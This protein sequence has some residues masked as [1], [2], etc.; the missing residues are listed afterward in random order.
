MPAHGLLLLAPVRAGHEEALR[1]TLNHFGN[2]IRG[3]RT[4]DAAT[5]PRLHFTRSHS[6]HF[7]R[8]T[9]LDD[10][11]RG[12]ARMR[13]LFASDYDGSREQHVREV[14]E[15][16]QSPEAIWGACEG[17]AGPERFDEFVRRHT[18]LPETH[19]IAFRGETLT[20]L[21]DAI[22]QKHEY[23]AWLADSRAD[24]VLRAWPDW[25]RIFEF[26]QGLARPL[27]R[28]FGGV[29]RALLAAVEVV[30]LM[31][32]RGCVR[33]LRAALQINSTLDRIWWIR[34]VNALFGNRPVPPPHFHS[35]ATPQSPPNPTPPG[36]PPEDAISQNQLTL[37]T[38]VLPQHRERLRA[39]L[40]LIDLFGR[41]LSPPGTLVGI[42]TI[43]TVRWTLLD[44]DQRLLMV[45]NYDG[46][47][48][49]YIDEFAEMILSGL[50]ALWT[51]APDYP[52]AGAQD[53][54]ALKQFL[55]RHQAPA[56]VFYSAYPETS[57]LNLKDDL[58]FARGTGRIFRQLITG[59][60]APT[61]ASAEATVRA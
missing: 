17:Y 30:A 11:K 38:D 46:S 60:P 54:A 41:H 56:N 24:Q 55:R 8:F 10:P 12:P 25:V 59:H 34:L 22:R 35:E 49:N 9:L 39:V 47:W 13:L 20:T 27:L 18:V 48:E 53:V 2:D 23:Q 52:R 50:D 31:R 28:F 37:L 26:L 57:V 4:A 36:Y 29:R 19:Y 33:I 6:I 42:S 5:A 44:D 1:A 15:L 21:R 3:T 58:E 61:L 16:T 51:A 43:H 32:R 14:I 45:S 7:A 40:A